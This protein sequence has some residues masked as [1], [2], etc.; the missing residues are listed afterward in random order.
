MPDSATLG[1]SLSVDGT[2]SDNYDSDASYD[3]CVHVPAAASSASASALVS[4][5]VCAHVVF[6]AC[7]FIGD[8]VFISV[9]AF[10]GV[11]VLIIAVSSS[12]YALCL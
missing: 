12:V 5:R 7:V 8:S 2:N 1:S 10:I 6:A 11:C 9:C 4:V 3:K